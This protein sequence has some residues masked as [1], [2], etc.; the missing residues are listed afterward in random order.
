MKKNGINMRYLGKIIKLTKLPYLR[1]MAEI[2][3]V[4]RVIRS[5]YRDHQKEFTTEHFR[6]RHDL[7]QL[8]AEAFSPRVSLSMRKIRIKQLRQEED[9]QSRLNSV[10]FLNLIFGTGL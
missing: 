2:E 3:G 7:A 6:S 5:L 1:V 10:D 8:I 4:S 9:K